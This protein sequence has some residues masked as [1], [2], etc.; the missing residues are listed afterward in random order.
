MTV[1]LQYPIR[2]SISYA[3]PRAHK[4]GYSARASP[5]GSGDHHKRRYHI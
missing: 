3:A 4:L 1:D 5:V 2:V